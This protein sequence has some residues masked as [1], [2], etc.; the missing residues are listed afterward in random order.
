[1]PPTFSST[2]AGP[3]SDTATMPEMIR[4]LWQAGME[5]QR[6][7]GEALRHEMVEMLSTQAR[8]SQCYQELAASRGPQDWIQAQASLMAAALTAT[9]ERARRMG[10]VAEEMRACCTAAVPAAQNG[11]GGMPPR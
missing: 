6:I 1:M 8:L 3:G 2:L 10:Q 11:T 7:S 4:P 5:A 9:A